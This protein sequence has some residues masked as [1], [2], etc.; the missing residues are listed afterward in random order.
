VLGASPF[1]AGLYDIAAWGPLAIVILAL[2]I[3]GVIGSRS[4]PSGGAALLAAGLAGLALLSL[5]SSLWAEADVRAAIEAHRFALYSA[6]AYLTAVLARGR[7]EAAWYLGGLTAGL[8]AA[9]LPVAA[10]LLTDG[11]AE[12]FFSRRLTFPTGYVNGQAAAL[13][14]PVFP[15]VAVAE[16][17]RHAW[18]RGGTAAAACLCLGLLALTQSRGAFAALALTALLVIALWPGRVER[19]ALLVLLLLALAPALPALLDLYRTPADGTP[20]RSDE[21]AAAVRT[22]LVCAAGAGAAWALGSALVRAWVADAPSRAHGLRMAGAAV[23]AVAATAPV[24]VAV[25][26]A[27]P[28]DRLE[29]QWNEFRS[30]EEED[31]GSE[32]LLTGAGNR[33]DYWRIALLEFDSAPVLGV[34]AGGYPEHYFRLRRTVEDVRQPHS[35]PLQV[36]AELG[37]AGALLLLV[38]A[39]GTITLLL[40]ARRRCSGAGP[41]GTLGVAASG[42]FLF[43]ASHSAVDWIHLL[44]GLTGGAIGAVAVLGASRARPPGRRALIAPAAIVILVAFAAAGIGR[45]TLTDHYERAAQDALARDPRDALARTRDAAALWSATVDGAVT[46]AAAHARL[47]D[48]GSARAQ[49]EAAARQAPSDFLPHALLGDLALRRGDRAL[50]LRDY[51]AALRRNPRD[52]RIRQL[53]TQLRTAER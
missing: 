13:A 32:R 45:L 2:T 12:E 17:A 34:G 20:L 26:T 39:A 18:Q 19:V 24:A 49:L 33:Y 52:P 15:L 50:A 35:L 46:A 6:I 47:G 36:L 10:T 28:L 42:M 31:R 53:L 16:R 23:I 11:A 44:P 8:L 38:A 1:W 7:E 43:W 30:L 37:L 29:R 5:L 14:L 9:A 21:I 40:G 48:Y 4:V 41:A 51:A 25:A 3:A 22:L 27:E